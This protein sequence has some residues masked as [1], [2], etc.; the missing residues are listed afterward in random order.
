MLKEVVQVLSVHL[1]CSLSSPKQEIQIKTASNFTKLN[2]FNYALWFSSTSVPWLYCKI[3]LM[4]LQPTSP[5][6]ETLFWNFGFSP[7][8][9]NHL[10]QTHCASAT[11]AR[12]FHCLRQMQMFEFHICT[13]TA[14]STFADKQ[15]TPPTTACGPRRLPVGVEGCRKRCR[16]RSAAE[17]TDCVCV[18]RCISPRLSGVDATPGASVRYR[19]LQTPTRSR[20]S[21]TN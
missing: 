20:L 18:A 2:F 11:N 16:R 6:T 7:A 14:T 3:L 15:Q 13:V 21:F 4:V 10:A 19:L 5:P 12:Q 17:K 1:F 9:W 8:V